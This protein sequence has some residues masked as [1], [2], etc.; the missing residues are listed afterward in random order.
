MY[1]SHS[2]SIKTARNSSNCDVKVTKRRQRAKNALHQTATVTDPR[3]PYSSASLDQLILQFTA[4]SHASTETPRDALR[5]QKLARLFAHYISNLSKWYDLSDPTFAFGVAV[6]QIALEEPL[7]FYAV[8]ALSAMHVCKTTAGSFRSTAELYHRRCV[9]LI[10]TIDEG[11]AV[12]A[13]GVALAAT[14]LL[15]SYEIIDSDIDPNMHLRGAYS[16]ISAKD[17]P[18]ENLHRGLLA[19]GFWNYLREDITFSLFEK[20][21]LKMD[22]AAIS[23]VSQYD[24]DH[25]YLNSI[26]LVLGNIINATFRDWLSVQ[27]WDA[28]FD[29]VQQWASTR[30]KRLGPFSKRPAGS[31]MDQGFPQVWFLQPCHAAAMHYFLVSVVILTVYANTESFPRLWTLHLLEH[32][33]MSKDALLEAL[34]LEVCGITF[35]NKTATVTVNAFG[36]I[37]YCL[38]TS[39]QDCL[40]LRQRSELTIASGAR[41]IRA[42]PA[43]QELTRRLLAY[44]SDTGWPVQR[45]ASDLETSWRAG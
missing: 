42:E 33:Q 30:P 11:D 26:T 31:G 25:D 35:T 3:D 38:S 16:M 37:A 45:F 4:Q 18:S 10:I 22:L 20:C 27:E 7:L 40:Y 1:A 44:K 39:P 12:M 2:I 23:P 8:I 34:A 14:C 13:A 29:L 19:S 9:Q 5:D 15:R 24:A 36:P 6:P 17:L 28:A 32:D 21:P 41:F 43:R